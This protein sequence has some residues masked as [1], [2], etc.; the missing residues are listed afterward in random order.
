MQFV[1]E[2]VSRVQGMCKLRG[3]FP[4]QPRRQNPV[5]L[6]RVSSFVKSTYPPW[7]LVRGPNITGFNCAAITLRT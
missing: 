5:L 2:A 4:E 3:L 7:C 6:T 1:V